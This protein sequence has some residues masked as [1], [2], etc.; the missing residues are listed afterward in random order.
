[1]MWS[2]Q[3]S[4]CSIG[5]LGSMTPVDVLYDF[6]GPRIFTF[7]TADGDLML[8]HQCDEDDETG[9]ARFVVVP[10]ELAIIDQLRQGEITVRQALHQPWSWLV[11]RRF[12]GGICT[13]WRV[14][15]QSL[16]EDALPE[17]GVYL[18]PEHAPLL[19]V[20]MIGEGIGTAGVPG[21]VVR[22]AIDGAT[23]A[24]K[25]L[26]ERVLQVR[27]IA[28]RPDEDIRRFYDLPASRFAFA[29]FEVAFKEPP[30]PA[31]IEAFDAERDVLA[32]VGELLQRGLDWATAGT[33]APLAEDEDWKS[34]L[35]ALSKL[36]PPSHGRVEQVQMG[37][38]LIHAAQRGPYVLSRATTKRVRNA[39]KRLVHDD[40][41]ISHEGFIREFDKDKLVFMLRDSAGMDIARCS[42]PEQL[43]DDVDT[44][45]DQD[46]LVII[47]GHRPAQ[48][49]LVEVVSIGRA[50][51]EPETV[52][53]ANS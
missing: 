2:V 29:S 5:F 45:F 25:A 19:S 49:Q 33:E 3:G 14:S 39:Y 6:D 50:A 12:G 8:A 43:F 27:R 24:L 17:A 52:D 44:A 34:V 32:D 16:P 21:S 28:G 35:E 15:L 26:T 22:R 13:A 41:P 48:S 10:T 40:L 36:V 37:G 7:Q 4:E 30:P 9:V 20:R 42:F 18:S 23:A 53:S 11:D 47:Q 51:T 46:L 31:Q 1:M 38:R